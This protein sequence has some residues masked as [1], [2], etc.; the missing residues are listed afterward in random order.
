MGIRNWCLVA[1]A[2]LA[3]G[4]LYGMS[5]PTTAPAYMLADVKR[6]NIERVVIATGTLAAVNMVTVGSELSGRVTA[7]HA[8]FNDT[9][10]AGQV[11]ARIDPRAFL[12]RVVLAE[13]DVTV[14]EVNIVQ[15]EAERDRAIAEQ[16][17]AEREFR[18]HLLLADQGHG[19][20]AAR[21]EAETRLAIARAQINVADAVILSAQALLEQRRAALKLAQVDVERTFIHSPVSGTVI[22]RNVDVGQTVVASLRAP[23]LFQIAQDL[24]RMKVEAHVDEA[25]I[26][27]IAAGMLFRFTV[28]AFPDREF[29]GRIEQIRWA[30]EVVQNVVTYKVVITADNEDLALLPGM[31]ARVVIVI[32]QREAVLTIPVAALRFRPEGVAQTATARLQ[33]PDGGGLPATIWRYVGGRP[34]QA[35]IVIGLSDDQSIEVRDGLLASD[36]VV[37]RLMPGRG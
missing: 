32:G 16:N 22:R 19:S 3:G 11:I 37:L 29:S 23:E 25:D 31:T 1:A 5:S 13:A 6:G 9:V 7:L 10:T 17:Q 26:R 15:R 28:D 21:E 30:P 35:Q 14:A 4:S 8:D 27:R 18:R 20:A 12:G 34:Q 24:K 36:A 2:V 33:L